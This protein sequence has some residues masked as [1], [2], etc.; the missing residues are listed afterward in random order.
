M[1]FCLHFFSS[2]TSFSGILE[3]TESELGMRYNLAEHNGNGNLSRFLTRKDYA[4]IERAYNTVS[5]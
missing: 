1:V 3:N 4:F 5:L 2:E